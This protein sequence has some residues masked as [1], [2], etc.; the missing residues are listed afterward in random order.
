MQDYLQQ[1]KVLAGKLAACATSIDE[2]VIILHTLDGLPLERRPI[3]TSIRID[4]QSHPDSLKKIK[5]HSSH[6]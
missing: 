1:I 6:V 2:Y 4:S 3:S 5:P